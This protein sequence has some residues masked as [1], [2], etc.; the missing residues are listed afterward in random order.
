MSARKYL[1][2]EGVSARFGT[3]PFFWNW[4]MWLM[5]CGCGCGCGVWGRGALGRVADGGCVEGVLCVWRVWVL[6]L[7]VGGR[8]GSGVRWG[9]RRVRWAAGMAGGG[10]MS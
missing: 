6:G 1:G 9:W 4:A 3:D 10:R 8:G 2:V 7:M 5:V